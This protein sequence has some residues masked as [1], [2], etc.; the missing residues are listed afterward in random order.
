MT[1]MAN[2]KNKQVCAWG[3]VTTPDSDGRCGQ[4]GGANFEYRNGHVL[5]ACGTRG[6][7]CVSCRAVKPEDW[8]NRGK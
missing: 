5:A 6:Y 8:R 2:G 3:Q 4:C 7:G 1:I